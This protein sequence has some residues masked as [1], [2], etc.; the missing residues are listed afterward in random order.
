MSEEDKFNL[1]KPAAEPVA[2]LSEGPA[3][4]ELPLADLRKAVDSAQA[5]GGVAMPGVEKAWFTAATNRSGDVRGARGGHRAYI[6]GQQ[7]ELHVLW[8]TSC[9]G[10]QGD[11][12][13][14][15]LQ[16]RDAPC[17]PVRN[18]GRRRVQWQ[19]DD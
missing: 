12:D 14:S 15:V 18:D 11:E 4:Y 5:G 2:Y 17:L 8:R 7:E 10:T 13:V 1:E 16:E 3:L 9:V 6:G 19:H